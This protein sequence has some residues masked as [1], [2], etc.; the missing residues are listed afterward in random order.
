VLEI[1]AIATTATEGCAFLTEPL[2]WIAV[3]AIG[4][5]GVCLLTLIGST[6]AAAIPRGSRSGTARRWD[7]RGVAIG[8]V[9]LALNA[10]LFWYAIYYPGSLSCPGGHMGF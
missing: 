2:E 10:L 6:L 9:G 8:L 3:L 1:V 7:P 5:A 4:L